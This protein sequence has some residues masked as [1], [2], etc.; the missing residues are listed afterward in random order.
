MLR[1][2]DKVSSVLEEEQEDHGQNRQY[3]YNMSTHLYP[4]RELGLAR[5]QIAGMLHA[6]RKC[7]MI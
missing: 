1:E 4:C 2:V 7:Q 3:S 6:C 5:L